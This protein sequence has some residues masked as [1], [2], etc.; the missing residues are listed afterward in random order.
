MNPSAHDIVLI[1]DA[2]G[3]LVELCGISMLE[4][5]LR[6]LQRQGVRQVTVL[7]ATPEPIATHI[8]KPSWARAQ[9]SAHLR[10]RGAGPIA[11]ADVV[12]GSNRTPESGQGLILVIPAAMHCD[13]RLVRALLQKESP[14]ILIDSD[15]PRVLQPL[16]EQAQRS[17]RGRVC[18]PLLI[19]SGQSMPGDDLS[20]HM[21]TAAESSAITVVDVA[22]QPVYIREM[23]RD[24]RPLWFPAPAADQVQLA[25][26][27]LLDAAQNGTLDFPARVHAPIE[28]WIISKLSKTRITPTQ[29]TLFTAVV[30]AAVTISFAS[31]ALL[32]GTFLA[33]L[34][35]ILDGLD[36]KQARVKVETTELGKREHLLDYVLELSWWT[37]LAHHFASTAQVPNAVGLLLL[38]VGADLA[39]RVAKQS[40]KKRLGCNLDDVAVIDRFVRLIGGRRNIYIWMFAAGLMLS[41]PGKT[42]VWLCWWGAI[43]AAVHVFRAIWIGL[44]RRTA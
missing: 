17:S 31:G 3:A 14:A 22:Q 10:A 41:A 26:R 35:G 40:V 34:V 11:L 1:A 23:R 19:E 25:E 43:T 13:P 16:L 9:I 39:D 6:T 24:L 18:G 2:P 8:A 33:L 15:P 29:V 28:T 30:S 21:V 27:L 37:A 44:Q 32:A 12:A 5:L 36:G 7:S 42:F 20:T 4:R 38:L